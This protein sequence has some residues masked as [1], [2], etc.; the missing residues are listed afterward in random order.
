MFECERAG[1]R[2]GGGGGGSACSS[3]CAH[4]AFCMRPGKIEAFLVASDAARLPSCAYLQESY[5]ALVVLVMDLISG[6]VV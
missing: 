3:K 5:T 6:I 4:L 2:G 1:H